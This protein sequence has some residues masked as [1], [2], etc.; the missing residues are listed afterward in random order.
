MEKF[1][2]FICG[3]SPYDTEESLLETLSGAFKGNEYT[4]IGTAFHS[5]VENGVAGLQSQNGIYDIEAEGRVVRLNKNHVEIA[6]AYRAGLKGASFEVKI[7]KDY[8]TPFFPIHVSGRT[9]IIHGLEVRDTKTKYSTPKMQDYCD[10]YQWR[11]YLD[12]LQAD[13]FYF[14]VFYFEKYKKEEHGTDVSSLILTPYEPIECIRYAQLE[15][16]TQQLVSDFCEY[17]TF[18]NYHHLLKLKEN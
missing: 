2:R 11:Y 13:T 1:R 14:D 16:D 15:Y 3:T 17:I 9:D 5:V 18:R 7:G 4:A 10:S 8:D 12:I 6:G